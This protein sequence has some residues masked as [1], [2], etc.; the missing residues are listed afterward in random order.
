M[1]V[2]TVGITDDQ[3]RRILELEENHFLDLKAVDIAPAK[4]TRTIAALSNASGGELYVGIDEAIT[5][6]RKNRSWRGFSD[7]EEANAHLQVFEQLFPLGQYYSYIFLS[8]SVGPGL[9]LQVTI[10]KTREITRAS[11][12]VVYLRRGAQN[13]TVTS[14]EA[15]ARLR[16]D[17]G[18]SS[19]ESET[20]DV[21]AQTVTNSVPILDFL[22]R[23]IPTAEPE[24]WLQKQQLLRSEKPTVAAILLFAEEPQAI[25]PKRSGVKIY[26]YR[27]SAAEGGRETLAFDPITIE[28]HL[29]VQIKNAVAKT[30]ELVEGIQKLGPRGL[31]AVTYPPETLHE[32][33][34]NA[35]LHRDYSIPVDVHI[36]IFDNR[37]EVESPGKLPGHVTPANILQE[38]FARNGAIVRIIN[39]F[40]DPPNK[41][42]GEGLN[43]AFAA[44][45][46]L[47]LKP[48]TIME[49]ENSVLVS[50]R[51]EALASPEEA[52]MEYLDTHDEIVNRIGREITGI[53]SENSMK[54]VFYRL[55]DRGL[56]EPVPGRVGFG[57]AWRKTR[58]NSGDTI[59][60]S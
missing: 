8:S 23:V 54:N 60:N 58:G 25:L 46:Q 38:Q 29:Y 45:S 48:P 3:A 42:V 27:T 20:I 56:I 34:T 47:R 59:L 43:T 31:E 37:I 41:D 2:S 40:P 21:A 49:R 44:M 18:I 13:L 7:T 6:G 12:S 33:V 22:V 50:I 16:L 53:T 28:G 5:S 39:K 36:R 51:H 19:F 55:R 57:S 17:K 35:L 15:L 32:I 14:Q 9:V 24:T 26:R 4:L 30:T 52:V 1:P 11:D 10:N